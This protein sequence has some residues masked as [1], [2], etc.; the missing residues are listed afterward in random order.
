MACDGY[1]HG[2]AVQVQRPIPGSDVRV[3]SVGHILEID[4]EQHLLDVVF[5]NYGLLRGLDAH[6]FVQYHGDPGE[7]QSTPIPAATA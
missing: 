7:G 2:D 1:E 4:S 5:K 3:G 6:C